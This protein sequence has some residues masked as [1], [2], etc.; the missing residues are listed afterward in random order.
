MQ[1]PWSFGRGLVGLLGMGLA[2]R[3]VMTQYAGFYDLSLAWSH[4]L[5]GLCWE[6]WWLR[7][8][9]RRCSFHTTTWSLA[10]RQRLKADLWSCSGS[11]RCLCG[12]TSSFDGQGEEASAQTT[13]GWALALRWEACKA[14]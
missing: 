14:V 13:S 3:G 10:V 6:P 11:C 7:L 1:G 12:H 9:S 5:W 4:V 2:W 8:N